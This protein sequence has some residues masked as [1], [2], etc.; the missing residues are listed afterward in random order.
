VGGI[1]EALDTVCSHA[2]GSGNN[3]LAGQY[4][5]ISLIF[6]ITLSIPSY[7]LW[8]FYMGDTIRLLGLSKKI[9]EMGLQFTRIELFSVFLGGLSEH[10]FFILDL[11]GHESFGALVDILENIVNTAVIAWIVMENDSADL[12]D[13]AYIHLVVAAVFFA[14]T[15]IHVMCFR[16]FPRRFMNGMM[17]NFALSNISAV[18]TLTGTS[19]PVMFGELVAYGEWEILTIFAA[20]LGPAEAAAWAILS[21]IWDMFE[22]STEGIGEAAAIRIAYHLGKGNPIMAKISAYKSSLLATIFGVLMTSIFFIAGDSIPVWFTRDATLQNLISQTIPLIG[23]GNITMTFG[24]L[25]WNQLGGQGRYSIATIFHLA[26]S[27]FI[28]L[29]LAAMSTY[30]FN[31]NLEGIVAS[32]VI[33]FSTLGMILSSILVASD[34]ERL[35]I[36]IRELV[37]LEE[38]DSSSSSSSSSSSESSSSSSS[39]DK[40]LS[41]ISV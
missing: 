19:I 24:M 31:F 40:S 9:A 28:T 29:P 16:W 11:T 2:M 22:S 18:K 10:I 6:Y 5:Q 7:G 3:Y 27:W 12:N 33:G 35:S 21:S 37:A 36:I 32:I 38:D 39:C 20:H 4:V 41:F 14:Y 25:A 26:C 13:V 15:T 34:W 8:W 1:G 23:I 17:R 30:A